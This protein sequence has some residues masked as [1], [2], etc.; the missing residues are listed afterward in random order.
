LVGKYR[1]TV[2]LRST[3]ISGIN[4][5]LFI[6]SLLSSYSLG[7]SVSYILPLDTYGRSLGL[8][9]T[10]FTL[11][12]GKEFKGLDITGKTAYFNPYDN[13]RLPYLAFDFIKIPRLD[14]SSFRTGRKGG[15]FL[16]SVILKNASPFRTG[17]FYSFKDC[18]WSAARF[19]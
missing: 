2:H 7:E 15:Q 1:E 11:K 14:T 4:D 10:H 8:D 3:N 5:S 6:N 13:L 12:L 16:F 19:D 18:S 9:F 17:N